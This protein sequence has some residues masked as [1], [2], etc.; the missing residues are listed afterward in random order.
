M[1][2]IKRLNSLKR[3]LASFVCV[4]VC[5]YTLRTAHASSISGSGNSTWK[6]VQ[7]WLRSA[8]VKTRRTHA[9]SSRTCT[10]TVPDFGR[11][12]Y[13]KKSRSRARCVRKEDARGRNETMKTSGHALDSGRL[14][15][16]KKLGKRRSR[17]RISSSKIDSRI[18]ER[19]AKKQSDRR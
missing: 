4:C 3:N 7:S 12:W 6:I 5:G 8:W 15:K 9:Q 18:F 10:S 11:D 13:N 1:T 16:W 14:F 2:F 17:K 19:K